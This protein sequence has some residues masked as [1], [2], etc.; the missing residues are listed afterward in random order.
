MEVKIRWRPHRGHWSSNFTGIES[1]LAKVCAL[2][3]NNLAGN[4]CYTSLPPHLR[5]QPTGNV[6][7]IPRWAA[8]G[9]RAPGEGSSLAGTGRGLRN[10]Q[11]DGYRADRR[12]EGRVQD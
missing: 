5:R 8:E 12:E 6:R 3:S 4:L 1:G 11:R 10:R 9:S 2:S 7:R